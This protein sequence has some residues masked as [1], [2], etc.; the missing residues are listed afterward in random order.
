[1]T[2]AGE[3]YRDKERQSKSWKNTWTY[4]FMTKLFRLSPSATHQI[5]L[6]CSDYVL[7]NSGL[8]W[9]SSFTWVKSC[10]VATA[11]YFRVCHGL[12]LHR[13]QSTLSAFRADAHRC[14]PVLDQ[15]PLSTG[16]IQT[17]QS[18]CS[19]SHYLFSPSSLSPVISTSGNLLRFSW[20]LSFMNVLRV[21]EKK[22]NS[23]SSGLGVQHL[24]VS[25]PLLIILIGH[26]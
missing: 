18:L 3:G 13:A 11:L 25:S 10:V 1:M 24:S 6:K 7:D 9:N 4:F 19:T 26:F 20:T 21:P 15:C 12:L 8:V 16:S 22:V 5:S 17:G 2:A 14:S 23:L